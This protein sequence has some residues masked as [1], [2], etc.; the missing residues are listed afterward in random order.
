MQYN[1][2]IIRTK[3]S[4]VDV[5]DSK[6]LPQRLS[7]TVVMLF[8]VWSNYLSLNCQQNENNLGLAHTY[9]KKLQ[10]ENMV[11]PGRRA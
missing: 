4:W 11:I 7:A 2:N 1:K 10:E 6:Q 9:F 5:I 8:P 3:T